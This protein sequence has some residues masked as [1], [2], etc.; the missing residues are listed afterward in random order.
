MV[1]D[2]VLAVGCDLCNNGLGLISVY[3]T[4][5]LTSIG[6]VQGREPT[7]QTDQNLD[8][9]TYLWY[10]SSL[11]TIEA[12]QIYYDSTSKVM[13]TSFAMSDPSLPTALFNLNLW[14]QQLFYTGSDLQVSMVTSCNAGETPSSSG[15]CEPCQVGY[16][17]LGVQSTCIE[18]GITAELMAAS[19]RTSAV[20]D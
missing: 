1:N 11:N 7:L 16:Y 9:T 15:V 6:T 12:A 3:D 19:T 2:H 14:K 4:A 17:S 5:T 8:L 20:I 13:E 10:I 18:C